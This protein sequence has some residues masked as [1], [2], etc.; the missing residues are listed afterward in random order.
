MVKQAYRVRNWP[1]YNKALVKR[2]SLTFWFNEGTLKDWYCSRLKETRGRPKKYSDDAIVC[3]LT[4]KALFKLPFRAVEGLINSLMKE[5]NWEAESPDYSLLCKR[6]KGLKIDFREETIN[7]KEGIHILVDA[8]GLKVFGEGEWK[9]RQHGIL[10]K[11]LWRQYQLAIN[12]HTQAIEAFELKALGFPEGAGLPLLIKQI[13]QPINSI[14]GDGAYDSYKAYKLAEEKGFKLIVPPNKVAKR[15]TECTGHS[16]KKKLTLEL[17]QALQCR[18]S[19]IERIRQIGRKAWKKEVLYHRRSL[20]ETAMFRIKTILG[21]RL[22]TRKLENNKI[23]AA[24]WCK[25][26]NHMTH[27]GMPR[28][29]AIN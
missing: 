3:G 2:G 6:Q 21:N 11:R 7:P 23:E 22:S 18:D 8:T 14:T 10:K 28:S 26:I 19:Y 5:F 25:I 9:V 24:I 12:A 27:L 16:I 4:L 1:Q 13:N 17:R 20:V 29:E 15:T